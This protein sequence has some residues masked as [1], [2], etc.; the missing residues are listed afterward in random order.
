MGCFSTP[1][2]IHGISTHQRAS[3]H[4]P[5]WVGF[6]T[7]KGIHG[8]STLPPKGQYFEATFCF[9][10]P[11][12]IHGISTANEQRI[13]DAE[14]N[15]VSVPRRV[16]MGFLQARRALRSMATVAWFQYSEGY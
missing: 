16:F 8:I 7:P 6:S 3:E 1:K 4:Y 14:A 13:A 10:T 15:E 5:L 9:S 11:K 12:G 2:G